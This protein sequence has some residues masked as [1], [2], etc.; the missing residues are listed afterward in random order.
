MI[1]NSPNLFVSADKTSNIYEVDPTTYKQLIANSVYPTYKKTDSETARNINLKAK[2]LT[3]A[4]KI[5]DRV[6]MMP[7]KEAYI[8]LKDH[9]PNF[10][11]SIK[12]RLINPC[13]SNIGKITK[14]ILDRVNDNIKTNLKLDQLKNTSAAI[15]WFKNI[16]AKHNKT[17]IQIDLVDYYP[18]VTEKLFD[19][20]IKFAE[21][22]TPITDIEKE[23]LLNARQSILYHDGNAWT[24]ISGQF[25]VT[26]G[27]Y[28]GAQFTDLVGLMILSKMKNAFP[29]IQFSLYRDDGLGHHTSMNKQSLDRIR[30][31][32]HKFFDQFELKKS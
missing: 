5:S 7:K 4:L 10:P 32:L 8:T 3:E 12:C 27:S 23:L 30:K 24:K 15:D 13:K 11:E 14:Q 31:R 25:D 19:T 16:P 22:I 1:N 29:E 17:F 6:E 9:K 28:D 26:M 21:E 20:T 2:E 18:S